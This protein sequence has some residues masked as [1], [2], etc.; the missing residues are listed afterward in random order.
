MP[1]RPCAACLRV[2]TRFVPLRRA[3]TRCRNRSLTPQNRH[4]GPPQIDFLPPYLLRPLV[5]PAPAPPHSPQT[6]MDCIEFKA[7]L[8]KAQEL[9]TRPNDDATPYATKYE[10]REVL[11]RAGGAG[12]G[13]R[14]PPPHHRPPNV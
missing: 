1:L 6:L 11:V 9:S 13:G 3:P 14:A 4:L 10:A 12:G 2:L 8:D 7:E 5:F